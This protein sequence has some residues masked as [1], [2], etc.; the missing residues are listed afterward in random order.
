MKKIIITATAICLSICLWAQGNKGITASRLAEGNLLFCVAE[1]GNN[2]TD[3][4]TGLDGRQI[5]HVA[6]YHNAGGKGFALE[7]IHKGGGVSHS[8]RQFHGETTCSG[9]GTTER[10]RRRGSLGG[11]G[12]AVYRYTIRLQFHAVGQC[13]V[14][15]RTGTEMLQEQGW[16]T[17]V[18]TDSDVVS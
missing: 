18:Q 12:N 11:E 2:I 10:H 14:L 15:Q 17:G 8:Y 1:S 6:I 3:V 4:T 7:A 5:D 13:D 9:S 16:R